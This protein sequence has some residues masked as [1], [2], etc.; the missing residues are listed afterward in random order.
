MAGKNKR[1]QAQKEEDHL[2]DSEEPMSK[3]DFNRMIAGRE[4]DRRAEEER[5]ELRLIA[6]EERAEKRRKAEKIDEEERAE[7]RD[8]AKWKRKI[9]EARAAA[10]IEAA[11]KLD[12]ARVTAEID[13]A[14]AR[15]AAEYEAAKEAAAKVAAEVL[16]EQQKAM[17]ERQF[18]QQERLMRLQAEMNASAANERR[19]E[20]EVTRSRERAVSSIST[21]KDGD[22]IEEYLMTAERKLRAGDVPVGEWLTHLAAK[23]VGKMGTTWQ[24]LCVDMTDYYE[25]KAK[26]LKIC[27]YTSKVAAELFFGFKSEQLRGMTAD[28][29]YLRG[30]QLFRRL[31][32]P[33]KVGEEAEFSILRGWV[34][35]IIPRK[36][37]V[38]LDM[39]A[40]N[41]VADLLGALHDHLMLE[42]DRT[43]GQAVVFRRQGHSQSSDVR[44]ERKGGAGLTCYKCGKPGH[45]AVDC[46]QVKG[47]TSSVAKSAGA[48]SSS[49]SVVKVI[50]CYTCG[51]RDISR[52]SAQRLR[53]RREVS[54]DG[55]A[56]PV[57][58]LGQFESTDTVL[59]GT[60]NGRKASVLLDSGASIT[61]VPEA[62]VEPSLL[63]GRSVAVRAFRS[64]EFM[65]LPTARV[66]FHV[67]NLEWEELVALKMAESLRCYIV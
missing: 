54:K 65:T 67:E 56:K 25:V 31:I 48:S 55:V 39:R 33:H 59:E 2:E 4:A 57:R 62:M 14:K 41:C 61:V 53:K 58:Q 19:L 12:E 66:N 43:E 42:G 30:V 24:D 9:E 46:W 17:A 29:V 50:T 38:A 3:G 23:L 16:M 36:A 27:G 64:K 35:Y 18:E 44:E 51:E 45:K 8:E 60:V 34:N 28:Q 40:V 13:I 22:D 6:A 26:L 32:A 10:E 37:K 5:A 52:L 63:T 47:G 15:A 49:S 11:R 1:N 7:C 21:Y 20:Q